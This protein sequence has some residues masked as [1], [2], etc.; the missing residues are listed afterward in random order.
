MPHADSTE[1]MVGTI[2]RRDFQF[3]RHFHGMQPGSAAKTQQRKAARIDAAAQ[4]HQPDAVGHLQ[5]DQPEDAGGSL[6]ARE[7]Q[8]AR[9]GIDGRFAGGAIEFSLA[10]EKIIGVEIAEQEIGVGD[11]RGRAALAIAGRAGDCARAFRADTKA[12]RIDP[13]DRSAAGADAGDVEAAQRDALA[14]EATLGGELCLAACDQRDVGRGAAHVERNKVGNAE[15]PGGTARTGDAAGWTRQHGR[16]RQPRCFRNRRHAAM[17]ENDEQAAGEAC[18]AEA[19]F[20]VRQVAM[21][22]R[23]D[24]GVHDRGRDP[25]DIP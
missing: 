17:R 3:T 18:L 8:R 23:P 12:R 10:A 6:L 16:D 1:A 24:I 25:L 22:R 20:E 7:V 11:G 15:Q 5:I 9:D 4:R 13:R 19:N 21:H 2:T 14:S